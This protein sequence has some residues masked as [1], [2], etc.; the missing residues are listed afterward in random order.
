MPSFLSLTLTLL[1]ACTV[2]GAVIPHTPDAPDPASSVLKVLQSSSSTSEIPD[3]SVQLVTPTSTD[4]RGNTPHVIDLTVDIVAPSSGFSVSALTPDMSTTDQFLFGVTLPA[5]L[6]AKAAKKPTSL[7]WGDDG[8]SHSQ[9]YPAGFNFLQS[10]MRHDFGYA[11]FKAQRRFTEANRKRI[12][13]NFLAD[14][15][16]ECAKQSF[17][18]GLACKATALVYHTAVR[19]FGNL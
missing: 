8:C 16:R 6:A 17:F 9:D 1:L 7:D 12:D 3:L 19:T 13:D 4:V 14:L 11:N 2:H 10:C 18:P 5:F 15:N